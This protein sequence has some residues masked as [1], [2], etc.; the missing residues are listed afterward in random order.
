MSYRYQIRECPFDQLEPHLRGLARRYISNGER[1][2][3]C[4]EAK[5][6]RS[7]FLGFSGNGFVGNICTQHRV[8]HVDWAPQ[9][10][11]YEGPAEDA[12]TM[13]LLSIDS[14]QERQT[15]NLFEVHLS[16][17]GENHLLVGFYHSQA[18]S[19]FAAVVRDAIAQAKATSSFTAPSN[20]VEE[21][22]RA[23]KQL[24]HDG[25]ITEAQ[26]QQKIQELVNQI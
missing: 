23:L 24:R 21:R 5:W 9:P 6:E 14:I 4:F 22:I 19:R 7:E 3:C 11:G 2:L 20:S 13:D 17:L 12:Q 8:I 18:A 15:S 26:F 10:I 16:G 25:L 1:I